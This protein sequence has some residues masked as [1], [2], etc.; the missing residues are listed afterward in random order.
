MNSNE[1]RSPATLKF[2]FIHYNVDEE[3]NTSETHFNS[4]KIHK[5]F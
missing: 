4:G 5:S 1:T 2:N 3:R